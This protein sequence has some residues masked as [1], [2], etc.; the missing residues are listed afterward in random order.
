M[1]TSSVHLVRI[2]LPLPV[3]TFNIGKVLEQKQRA[4][5]VNRTLWIARRWMPQCASY[6]EEAR[7]VYRLN[8]FIKTG[9]EQMQLQ[10]MHTRFIL[11]FYISRFLSTQKNILV[12]FSIF[13]PTTA[14]RASDPFDLLWN[15]FHTTQQSLELWDIL[16]L[17]TLTTCI[18][19]SHR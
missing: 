3:A 5:I 10:A 6:W 1:S 14:I 13:P 17:M 8:V 4:S 18:D 15:S 2:C 16:S 7:S 11:I 9:D 19:H 12:L